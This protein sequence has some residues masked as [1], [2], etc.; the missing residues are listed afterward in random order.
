[1]H[2]LLSTQYINLAGAKDREVDVLDS[3]RLLLFQFSNPVL[4]VVVYT[5]KNSSFSFI[6]EKH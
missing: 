6:A 4:S 2:T 1:M 5:Q 3:F